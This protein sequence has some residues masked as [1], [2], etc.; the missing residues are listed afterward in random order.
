MEGPEP[1]LEL[2]YVQLE[3]GIF[4]PPLLI[5]FIYTVTVSLV[6]VSPSQGYR[7]PNKNSRLILFSKLNS[8][9]IKY[10]QEVLSKKGI[11][12]KVLFFYFYPPSIKQRYPPT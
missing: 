10:V 4:K 7:F 1:L 12:T 5:I 2:V 3:P 8:A 9:Y 11:I 6:A